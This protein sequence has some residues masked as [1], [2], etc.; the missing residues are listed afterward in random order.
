MHYSGIVVVAKPLRVGDCQRE[1]ENL[2]GVEVHYCEPESGRLVVVQ[3]TGSAEEQDRGLRRIQAL[4]VVE[5]AALV[6]HRI[7]NEDREDVSSR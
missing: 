6:E 5:T 4:P 2:P 1:L 3:E 7:D